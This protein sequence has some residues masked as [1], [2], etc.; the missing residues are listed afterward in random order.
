MAGN[1]EA[2]PIDTFV[3]NLYSRSLASRATHS[4]GYGQFPRSICQ[5]ASASSDMSVPVA[6]IL[7]SLPWLN[8][9]SFGPIPASEPLLFSGFC[10][11]VLIGVMG[12][13]SAR[14]TGEELMSAAAL[15]WIFAAV[16]SSSLG[17]L[18]YVGAT[19]PFG[20]WVNAT[21]PGEAFANLRQRN[22]FATLTNIGLLAL[23]GWSVQT[24]VTTLLPGVVWPIVMALLIG[25][26]NAASSSRTGLVQL[27]LIALLM[28][29]W[30][31]L[32]QPS[33]RRVV[34][35]AGAGYVLAL[36]ALPWLIGA[37][38]STSGAVARLQAGDS[39]C[40]SRLT[41]WGNVLHLITQKPWLGWGWGEL[42]YAHFV[43]L[44]P[45]VRF[46]AILD[47]AHNL[48][49]HLAVELGVPAALLICGGGLW[50][51]WRAKP[52]REKDAT[53]Q[54]AWG[55]LAV[56]LLHSM[57]E[58]P[59]WYGPF[60]MAFG[61]CLWL[62]WRTRSGTVALTNTGSGGFTPRMK[63]GLVL[64]SIALLAAIAYAAW[65]YRRVSQ[66]YLTPATRSAAYR[67]DTLNKIKNS[68]LFQNQV[69]F[70]ELTTTPLTAENAPRLNA[71]ALQLLH[72]SPEPSVIEKLIESAVLMGK[73]TEAQ[74]Y[75]QRYRA[76]FP[77]QSMRRF[78]API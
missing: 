68:W 18:Q 35:A 23:I 39:A 49:L 11:A 17:L 6:I 4:L 63:I 46:C 16:L 32:N 59:L 22:Q 45:G 52:W 58:F 72:F 65:D 67:D 29:V 37:D 71:L 73:N 69:R 33:V 13:T 5:F 8:P 36:I 53:R 21:Q 3:N 78:D 15:A 57:L 62:L 24:R 9:F 34:L 28:M 25:A 20:S 44:Y 48:P 19:A 74:F 38:P 55:V 66:I 27:V 54:L 61:L 50:L 77:D 76:A 2:D 7:I 26:G 42:D 10:V 40:S 12:A 64:I 31:R 1:S 41:L 56:I 75:L 43:T 51:A 70:A 14:C 60:Q 47:N 30:G